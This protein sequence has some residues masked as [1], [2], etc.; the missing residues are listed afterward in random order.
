MQVRI[1]QPAKS[2][3]TSGRAKTAQWL[4]EPVLETKR[5]PEP[6]MGWTAAGDTLV[7]LL[8]RLKFPTA[9]AAS[10]FAKEKG[11]AYMVIPPHERQVQPRNYLDN[12]KYQPPTAPVTGTV[13]GKAPTEKTEEKAS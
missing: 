13:G 4:I 12:F 1:Y 6:L 5:A 3:M 2:A 9:E 11:W 8:G 10:T 7:E